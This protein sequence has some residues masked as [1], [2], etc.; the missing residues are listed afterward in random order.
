MIVGLEAVAARFAASMS[1]KARDKG[2]Y[3]PPKSAR[4]ANAGEE[5]PLP[6]V[7]RLAKALADPS[8]APSTPRD[9]GLNDVRKLSKPLVFGVLERRE[10]IVVMVHKISC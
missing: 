6:P 4:R 1:G 5:Q 8:N 10:Q 2:A 7:R 3:D 9:L